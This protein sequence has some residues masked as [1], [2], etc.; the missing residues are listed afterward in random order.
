MEKAHRVASEF[1]NMM[2]IS[3][4]NSD[5]MASVFSAKDELCYLLIVKEVKEMSRNLRK[6]LRMCEKE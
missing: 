3:R 4:W 5:G 6:A 2:V 1:I